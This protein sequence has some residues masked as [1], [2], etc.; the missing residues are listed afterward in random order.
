MFFGQFLWAIPS[1][2]PRHPSLTR[3]QQASCF[4]NVL[5]TFYDVVGDADSPIS[6][7]AKVLLP[8][9]E[10]FSKKD[11]STSLLLK[12][13]NRLMFGEIFMVSN[14]DGV[15]KSAKSGSHDTSISGLLWTMAH[16]SNIRV[17]RSSC[18]RFL[19][20]FCKIMA[21]MI[22]FTVPVSLSYTP[23]ISGTCGGLNF[24][25]LRIIGQVP[26]Q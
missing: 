23:S 20:C 21:F 3:D 8:L 11:R 7:C 6:I 17:I 1:A 26:P 12:G 19:P 25:I 18:V 13:G 24:Q 15:S 5:A 4:W 14:M 10:K 16:I 2:M 9:F 22:R